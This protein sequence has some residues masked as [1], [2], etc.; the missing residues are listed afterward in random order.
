MEKWK[1]LDCYEK[2]LLANPQ[3][4]MFY[5]MQ[6]EKY[7]KEV[8]DTATRITNRYYSLLTIILGLVSFTVS[9]SVAYSGKF[10]GYV[11]ILATLMFLLFIFMVLQQIKLR[12][13][14]SIGYSPSEFLTD[15]SF[16]YYRYQNDDVYGNTIVKTI[17]THEDWIAEQE[18]R[19]KERCEKFNLIVKLFATS[20]VV[21]I[22]IGLIYAILCY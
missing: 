21:I 13:T 17:N 19:N 18:L 6:S 7:L 12:K 20:L 3:L 9:V 2:E 8:I 4:A 15:N 11:A 22:L 14:K 16:E 5:W 1:M 10:V